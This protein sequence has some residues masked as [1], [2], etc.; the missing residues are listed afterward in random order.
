MAITEQTKTEVDLNDLHE[1]LHVV[2]KVDEKLYGYDPAKSTI[3]DNLEIDL[4]GTM[5]E[6]YVESYRK[7]RGKLFEFREIVFT[8]SSGLQYDVKSCRQVGVS[9]MR[10]E[11]KGLRDL[12]SQFL[13][14]NQNGFHE[15]IK[16]R[17]GE[18]QNFHSGQ[19][20]PIV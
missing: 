2:H 4:D 8:A 5:K 6:V 7:P 16:N 10:V 18:Y 9:K 12:K 1:I 14:K 3:I 20:E 13:L 15:A 17:Y 19:F 11:L